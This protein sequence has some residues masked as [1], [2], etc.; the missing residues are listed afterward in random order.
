MH[1]G[2]ESAVIVSYQIIS[3]SKKVEMPCRDLRMMVWL[4]AG[5][6]KENAGR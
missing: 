4:R 5:P 6:G 3:G 2:P 1:K